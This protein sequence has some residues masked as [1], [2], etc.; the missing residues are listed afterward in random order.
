MLAYIMLKNDDNMK[1]KA[2]A[3]GIREDM[4][5]EEFRSR[6]TSR[7]TGCTPL[8]PFVLAKS[9]RFSSGLLKDQVGCADAQVA[10]C[11]SADAVLS[12]FAANRLAAER[13]NLAQPA[14]SV[15]PAFRV[16]VDTAVVLSLSLPR[17]STMII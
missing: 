4:L 16:L 7:T 10:P 9:D 6:S 13:M 17:S 5:S 11:H 8:L 3:V 15:D 12:D 2:R 1:Q 14:C